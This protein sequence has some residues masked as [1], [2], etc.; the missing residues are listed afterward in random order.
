[1]IGL[2]RLIVIGFLVLSAVYLLLAIYSRSVERERLEK[3]WDAAPPEGSGESERQAHIEKGM[4]HY[5][6]GLRRR[7]LWLV[8]VIP[9]I[10]IGVIVYFIN[11]R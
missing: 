1:M 6:H 3:E 11:Y 9:T 7:L 2:I 8:Y 4:Q 5:E 10:A